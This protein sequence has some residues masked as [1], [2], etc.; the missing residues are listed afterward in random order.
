[1]AQEAV[2]AGVDIVND[3]SG[4]LFDDGMLRTVGDLDVPLILMHMRGTPD[5]MQDHSEYDDVV[6]TVSRHLQHRSRVAE[7][8]GVFRWVQIVDPGFGFA[9][10]VSNNLDLLRNIGRIREFVNFVPLLLG[11]SRKS[12]IGKITG[13][14]NPAD[15]DPG[16]LA[17]LAA[18]LCLEAYAPG[19]N[20]SRLQL[21]KKCTIVRVHD[22]IGTRQAMGLVDAI[23]EQ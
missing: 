15:R 9:K 1:V 18:A 16:T 3:V 6:E 2:A 17:T 21:N 23:T 7:E 20:K 13:V 8:A 19:C 14:L 5:T 11:T 10:D 4:G 22:V 12:F